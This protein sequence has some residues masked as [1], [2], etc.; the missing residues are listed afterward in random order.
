MAKRQPRKPPMSS[1]SDTTMAASALCATM[2]LHTDS[3][4]ARHTIE[5]I[6]E[7]SCVPRWRSTPTTPAREL[8]Y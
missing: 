1:A 3:T 4:C 5:V 6:I 7:G 8:C 2:A